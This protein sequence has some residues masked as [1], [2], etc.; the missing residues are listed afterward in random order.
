MADE[1]KRLACQI[2]RYLGENPNAQDSLEG[3]I[4][5]WLTAHLAK[6][7]I[8]TVKEVLEDL[9]LSDLILERQGKDAQTYYRINM[10]RLE[11]IYAFLKE[12]D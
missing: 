2:L 8:G 5:W 3:I 6:T 4:Q 10:R 12:E 7:R 11:E 9:V 1:S